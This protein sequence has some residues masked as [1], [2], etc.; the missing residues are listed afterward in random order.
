MSQHIRAGSKFAPFSETAKKMAK[1]ATATGR[2]DSMKH[3]VTEVIFSPGG[4]AERISGMFRAFAGWLPFALPF[5]LAALETA[6]KLL[7]KFLRQ[8]K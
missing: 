1:E 6:K 5:L 4:S 3:K 2:T 8:K 7:Q